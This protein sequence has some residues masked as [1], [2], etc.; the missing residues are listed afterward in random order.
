MN[1]AHLSCHDASPLATRTAASR[2]TVGRRNG[3]EA[4]MTKCPENFLRAVRLGGMVALTFAFW[5]PQLAF[6]LTPL[7]Y[8]GAVP[9]EESRSQVQFRGHRDG[10]VLSGRVVLKGT[11]FYVVGKFADDGTVSGEATLANG[12]PIATFRAEAD[13]DEAIA[14]DC[15]VRGKARRFAVPVKASDVAQLRR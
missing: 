13:G 15:T 2:G 14:I 1:D 7:S 6:G 11:E 4:R 10:D 3:K 8:S 9:V 12:T 5:T